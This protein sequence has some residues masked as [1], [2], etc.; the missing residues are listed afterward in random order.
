MNAPNQTSSRSLCR[1][2]ILKCSLYAGLTAPLSAGLWLSGCTKRSGARR[3]NIILIT[4]DT[5]RADHL[6]CYGYHRDTSPNIDQFASEGMLF[7]KCFSH[8]S[9]TRP[10]FACIFSGFLPREVTVL[11]SKRLLPSAKTIPQMLPPFEYKTIAVVSNYVLSRRWGWG[12]RYMIYDDTLNERELVRKWPER[13]AKNT[14]DRAIELLN[15]FQKERFFMWIHY[16]DPHG[17]YAP[18]EHL[19]KLFWNPDSHKPRNLKLS[20]SKTGDGGI[21]SYQRLPGTLDYHY[22][23]SQYD[24][25]IRYAD[26]Q[27]KRLIDALKQLKLYD[28]SFII[29][30][31]DHGEGMGEHNYYFAHGEYS[32]NHQTHVPLIIKHGSQLQGRRCDYVQHLDIVPTVLNV[33]GT[34]G[35]SRLRGYDLRQADAPEREIFATSKKHQSL[36]H[37]SFKLIYAFKLKRYKTQIPGLYAITSLIRRLIIRY[38]IIVPFCFSC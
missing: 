36:I 35:D 22:Y 23:V 28:N 17:P 21:P 31:S 5:L 1:R 9:E 25:E 3:P 15:Q 34:V 10:S 4:I 18:P 29:F 16:Q 11:K 24:A 26:Q 7:E 33:V 32:Y 19:R 2:Q 20:G 38:Y 37:D 8:A 27:F 12:A 14:T 30:S 6:K 13:T